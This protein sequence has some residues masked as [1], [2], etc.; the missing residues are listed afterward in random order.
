MRQ[1]ADLDSNL[2]TSLSNCLSDHSI[3]ST[4]Y[5]A[6]LPNDVQSLYAN[7][8]NGTTYTIPNCP[9][10]ST[11]ATFTRVCDTDFGSG[12][13]GEHGAGVVSHLLGT[14]AYSFEDCV[15][16]CDNFNSQQVFFGRQNM[17]GTGTGMWCYAMSWQS[18]LSS[19]YQ[20]YGAN[21][22]LKNDTLAD[23]S[24]AFGAQGVHSAVLSTDAVYTN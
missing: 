18:G 9:I 19:S 7:C 3:S 16:A 12:T 2:Q 15:A 1:P 24:L 17:D 14:I 10:C 6:L 5:A 22:W 11:G 4:D 23:M 13:A 20:A 21:C 8:K